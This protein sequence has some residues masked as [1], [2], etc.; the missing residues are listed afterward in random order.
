MKIL[1]MTIILLLTYPTVYAIDGE[2]YFGH[3]FDIDSAKNN[4][5]AAPN[6]DEIAEYIFGVKLNENIGIFNIYGDIST[7]MDERAGTFFHPAS[8]SYDIGI[9]LDIQKF[10]ISLEHQCW[11]PVDS[12]ANEFDDVE[13]YNQ[14]M[15]R[16]KF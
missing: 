1:L 16:Y 4:K 14:V 13:V 3:F 9:S 10:T 11:H 15:L 8:V 6:T 2:V 5:S 12:E 7:L